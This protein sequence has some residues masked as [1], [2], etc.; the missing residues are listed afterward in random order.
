MKIESEITNA[1]EFK[2]TLGRWKQE[3]IEATRDEIENTTKKVQNT[4]RDLAPE[5]T[6]NLV[7]HFQHFIQTNGMVGVVYNNAE[8]ARRIELGFEDIDSRGREYN[9]KGQFMLTRAFEREIRGFERRVKTRI[10]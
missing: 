3:V 9:Q 4:A 2:A 1:R 8:Y 10:N 6:G 7:D 5:I